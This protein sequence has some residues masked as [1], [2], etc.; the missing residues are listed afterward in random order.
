MSPLLTDIQPTKGAYI[1]G[2]TQ[3]TQLDKIRKEPPTADGPCDHVSN[4]E[5][6]VNGDKK[7]V[8]S[9]WGEFLL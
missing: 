8:V 7:M 3:K 4:G 6:T 9:V 1:D 2:Y 5:M